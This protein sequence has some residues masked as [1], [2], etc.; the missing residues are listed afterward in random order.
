MPKSNVEKF[1]LP[2]HCM[3]SWGFI[4]FAPFNFI[5]PDFQEPN[6][7]GICFA[8]LLF[9]ETVHPTFRLCHPLHLLP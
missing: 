8:P 6:P 9:P 5:P 2:R 1:I 7:V 4:M 3:T